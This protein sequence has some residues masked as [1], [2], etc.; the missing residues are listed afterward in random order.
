M[1]YIDDVCPFLNNSIA[2]KTSFGCVKRALEGWRGGRVEGIKFTRYITIYILIFYFY[3]GYI[4]S[5]TFHPSTYYYIS[6]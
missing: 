4:P 3:M 1:V 2:F 5:I 6:I